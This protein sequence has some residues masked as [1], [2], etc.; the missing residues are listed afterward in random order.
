[1]SFV[2][3][4]EHATQENTNFRKV[5]FTAPHSQLVLMCLQPNEDIG[6]ETHDNVDQFIRVEKG[7][8]KAIL[9]GIDYDLADGSAVVI[10]AGTQHNIVNASTTDQMKLYTVY[11]PAEHPDGVIDTTKEDAIRRH[12]EEN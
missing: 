4:L 10:S 12:T 11:T 2:I 7:V 1:M 3:N 6:M 9:D 5:L 8:G